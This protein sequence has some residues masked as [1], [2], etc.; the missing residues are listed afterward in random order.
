VYALSCLIADAL[1]QWLT[2]MALPH[3][4]VESH[5]ARTVRREGKSRPLRFPIH[6]LIP[7]AVVPISTIAALWIACPLRSRVYAPSTFY[8]S[9]SKLHGRDGR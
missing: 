9:G 3:F 1:H 2:L 6:R 4:I 8:T 7:P 5:T